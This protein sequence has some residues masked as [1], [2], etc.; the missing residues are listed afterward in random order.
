MD[1]E[2]DPM[3]KAARTHW[4]RILN[5]LDSHLTTEFIEGMNSRI[6]AAKS[7]ARGYR[8]DKGFITIAYL[9]GAKLEFNSP[10]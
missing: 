7:K 6:R 10:T 3:V 5:W 8:S 4:S 2:F 9:L 1:S